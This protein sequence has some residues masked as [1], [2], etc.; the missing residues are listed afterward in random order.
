[1]SKIDSRI[2]ELKFN[3]S[4]FERGIR[5]TQ[6]G[7][8]ELDASLKLDGIGKG[9][10]NIASKF[11]P[12]T[13]IAFSALQ[14]LTNGAID[15][16]LRIGNAITGPLIEGGKKRALSIQQAK[17]QFEGLGM[18]V[19]Q[20]MEDALY[21]VK[22]TAFGLDEA[23]MA[24]SMFGA[25]GIKSG[26][27]M[28]TA[29]RGIA[30]VA[31]MSGS[32][33]TDMANVFTK[34]AGQGRVMADDLNRLSARGM[35]A[36][37]TIAEYMTEMGDGANYTEAQIRE[38]V[39]KGEIDF[40]LFADAMSSAFGEHAT[41]A[42]ET[43]AGSVANIGAA[44]ARIGEMHYA[45][46]FIRQ[47]DLF[48][49]LTPV[50]DG[51]AHAVKPMIEGFATLARIRYD[52]LINFIENLGFADLTDDFTPPVVQGLMNIGDAIFKISERIQDAWFKVFPPASE[53]SVKN[54]MSA[55]ERFTEA[56]KPSEETLNKVFKS[57]R[58]LFSI[59]GIGWEV[60]KAVASGIATFIGEVSGGVGVVLDF[61]GTIGDWLFSIYEAIKAGDDLTNFFKG[62]GQIV[63]APIRFIIDLAS[64]LSG[65]GSGIAT[66]VGGAGAFIAA[67]FGIGEE[68]GSTS[69]IAERFAGVMESLG[70]IGEFLARVW[71]GFKNVLGG[72]GEFLSPLVGLIAGVASKLF[73]PIKDLFASEGLDG[74]LDIVNSGV[75]V[76]VGKAIYD[77]FKSLTD[78]A[79]DSG[80]ITDGIKEIFGGLTDSLGALQNT[81]KAQTLITIAGAI[82]LLAGS[83]FVLSRIDGADLA[84]SL[85]GI[86][87]MFGQL[88]GVLF[89]FQKIA[90]MG[91]LL[92]LPV[93]AAGLILLSGA[94][95]LFSVAVK[96]LADLNWNE[97][98]KGIA[99]VTALLGAMVGF[100][101]LMPKNAPGM[102][103]AGIGMTIMAAALHILAGAV[104]KLADLTWHELSRG[105]AAVGVGLGLIAGAMRIMP[106]KGM[107]ASGT[108]LVVVASALHILAGAVSKF[109]NLDWDEM[110]R[111]LAGVAGSLT[112]I[113]I[114]LRLMPKGM[115]ATGT[116]LV[117]VASALHILSG[118]MKSFSAIQW[119]EM[120]RG[121]SSLGGSLVIIAV[122]M[123]LIPKNLIVTA[124]GLVILGQALGTISDVMKSLGGMSWD[125]IGRSLVVLAGSLVILAG[126]LHLMSGTLVGSAS[127]VIAASAL[128]ILTPVLQKLGGMEWDEIGRGLTMLAGSLVILAGGMYL[129][130]GAIVGAAA[131]VVVAGALT[132]LTPVLIA[133]GNMS[134]GEIGRGL[135]M[136]AASLAV[137]GVAGLVI[138]PLVP[139]L[140]GL[141]AAIAL[142]G[143]G[144]ALAGAGIL[145]FASGLAT[146]VGLGAGGIAVLVASLRAIIDLIPSFMKAIGTGIVG[147]IAAIGEGATQIASSIGDIIVAL[148]Q[149][150]GRIIPEMV[151]FGVEVI[152]AFLEGLEQVLPQIAETGKKVIV[153]FLDATQ[154]VIPKIIETAEIVITAFLESAERMTPKITQTGINIFIAFVEGLTDRMDDIT[155]A[156]GDL[157]VAFIEG[158][159]ANMSDI[160]SAAVD[161]IV[162]FIEGITEGVVK[163]TT[164]VGELIVAFIGALEDQTTDIVEAGVSLIVSFIEGI[165]EG[166]KDIAKAAGEAVTEFIEEIDAQTQNIIDAGTNLIV[167]FLEGIG[168]SSVK[169][170]KAASQM[171][172]DFLGALEKETPQII[173]AG[174]DFIIAVLNG[175]GEE[176]PRVA[177]AVVDL[178]E[179]LGQSV[180]DNTG[181]L[182]D[183]GFDIV[184]GIMDAITDTIDE[185]SGELSTSAEALGEAI[186]DG[187]VA[188]LDGLTGGMLNRILEIGQDIIDWFKGVLG[189]QSPSTKTAEMGR[190]LI[191]GLINGLG[192]KLGELQATI[193]SIG[194]NVVNWFGEKLGLGGGSGPSS[195]TKPM[196]SGLLQGLIGGMG[197]VMNPL[198]TTTRGVASST[199]NW[200][201]QR[202]GIS[203]RTSKTTNGF[204]GALMTGLGGGILG[205]V[206]GVNKNATSIATGVIGR[207]STNLG[208]SGSTS[209]KTRNFGGALMTG[210]G[211][212]ISS[213]KTGVLR[214][215]TQT[216]TQTIGTFKA[217]LT[218]NA[219]RNSGSSLMTGVSSGISSQW[220]S[221]SRNVSTVSRNT[222][223]RFQS[224]MSSR[225]LYNSGVNVM[226]GLR[227][228]IVGMAGSLYRTAS[229][230]A[231]NIARTI[232]NAL[233]IKSPSRVMMEIG[234]Y[235]GEGL[236]VGIESMEAKV[237]KSSESLGL[238][239]MNK[240]QNSVR[241]AGDI[242]GSEINRDI[243]I[244]PILDLDLARGQLSDL[245]KTLSSQTLNVSLSHSQ[246]SSISGMLNT[247]RRV[248]ESHIGNEEAP[249]QYIQNITS[250]KSLSEGEIYRN[251]KSLIAMKNSGGKV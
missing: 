21:A 104:K 190:N 173:K 70:G 53:A 169:I 218:S 231:A 8:K 215:V 81:L 64:N 105:M 90:G 151:D 100:M 211:G 101:H 240:L 168:K 229:N 14:R 86:T 37:A 6:Q 182:A 152:M 148:L 239:T 241:S 149:E 71:G 12:L 107:I 248:S 154:E 13:A 45:P 19:E 161:L 209:S 123:R 234:E 180:V 42:S 132:I 197:A 156:V 110:F 201:S 138:G 1:M 11:N 69:T 34:V 38:M 247:D 74:V 97:L 41:K 128:T 114:G 219:T 122:A 176:I 77:F 232:K 249:V 111:G 28:Q 17:F 7:M 137:I 196:G 208:I 217:R 225:S 43:Y 85:T 160:Q 174:A 30:G 205:G 66:V 212:G 26:E 73:E 2:V 175:M 222:I 192:E 61:T 245:A 181:R 158:I 59:L 210:I 52:H 25:S 170:A 125:E 115:V 143:A 183:I 22:G 166:A 153:S 157:I 198:G 134:W 140:L 141:G 220:P 131:L 47:R 65:L 199:I 75:L 135:T 36:A 159:T 93:A 109:S 133:L 10:D 16:G 127:L 142:L 92:Q 250:P 121:F 226:S 195:K 99:G 4:D 202:L 146:L 39:S 31:A 55:F 57:F 164:A 29:L 184:I 213:G 124:T 177:T 189:I 243:S 9:I 62:L 206:G 5:K 46:H 68:A 51:I 204:G 178:I 185:R 230:I 203:G 89:L 40:K 98:A 129:M 244:R 72:I 60:I 95:L 108:G 106:S 221:L 103:R 155:T 49:S 63:A 113:A 58:G 118:A 216:S 54:M 83:L 33:Y 165:G 119:D 223:S 15:F 32:S 162:A 20:S 144:A 238:E 116:G 167:N 246:A 194:S 187:I 136:L 82:A 214:N 186:I 171:I 227:N 3:T 150:F 79:D 56:L 224:N 88:M 179:V 23:A 200:F 76:M 126:A 112:A 130:T 147:A 251:T 207:F 27:E 191:Q 139:A 235:V 117:I 237:G 145:A 24:A 96:S 80:S 120:G 48:N 67:L 236:V 172:Q 193:T 91:S 78:T 18:D 188:G 233:K 87:I 44:L 94:L 50:I 242:L 84:K 35:N 228:G 102:I 163:V